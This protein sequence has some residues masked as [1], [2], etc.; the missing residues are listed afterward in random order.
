[1]D[2]SEHLRENI[3]EDF[4]PYVTLIPIGNSCYDGQF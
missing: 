3:K 2:D 1:M 4:I